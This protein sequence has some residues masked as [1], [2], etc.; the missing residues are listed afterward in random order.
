MSKFVIT[1]REYTQLVEKRQTMS[2][3]VESS[4]NFSFGDYNLLFFAK[5]NADFQNF[6]R[7]KDGFIGFI[8]TPIFFHGYTHEK[9]YSIFRE[10][11]LGDIC[12][13]IGGH[14]V[15]LICKHNQL[16]VISDGIGSIDIFYGLGQKSIISNDISCASIGSSLNYDVDICEIESVYLT[17]GRSTVFPEIKKI[18]GGVEYIRIEMTGQSSVLKHNNPIKRRLDQFSKWSETDYFS[19]VRTVFQEISRSNE[20]VG[21]NF[22]GGLDGRT[23]LASLLD[24][25][26]NVEFYYGQGNSQITNT[27]SR[28]LEIAS[29]ISLNLKIPKHLMDWSTCES[30]LSDEAVLNDYISLGV[31]ARVHGGSEAFVQSLIVRNRDR[32]DIVFMGGFSPGFSNKDFHERDYPTFNAIVEDC[33]K[34]PLE[35]VAFKF[36][37]PVF[38][39]FYQECKAYCLAHEL[40]DDHDRLLVEGHVI[41]SLLY[42][43]PE[44]EHLQL[45][46]L[47]DKYVAPYNTNELLIPMLSLDKVLRRGRK[48]QL[49]LIHLLRP[50]LLHY[51]L[52]SGIVDRKISEKLEINTLKKEKKSIRIPIKYLAYRYYIFKTPFSKKYQGQDLELYT[53]MLKEMNSHYKSRWYGFT[54][55]NLRYCL[56]LR[57]AYRLSTYQKRL[58]EKL[59]D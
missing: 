57:F 54:I 58:E 50:D 56:R 38:K 2:F 19:R 34:G 13:V 47:F 21:L 5:K 26:A 24:I 42:I 28:D 3:N 4:C 53:A 16:F 35:S 33:L 32:R 44:S 10:S 52:F 59:A 12:E 22:T 20:L 11:N 18:I 55:F 51:R 27:Q 30:D 9:I 31:F 49:N 8:G 15:L 29:E 46:N 14:Y 40:I 45:F 6:V 36:Y 43:R 48:L 17:P 7:F 37:K 1:P 41:R 25:G 23:I 39:K